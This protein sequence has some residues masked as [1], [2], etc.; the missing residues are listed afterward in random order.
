VTKFKKELIKLTAQRKQ[1]LEE[2]QAAIEYAQQQKQENDNLNNKLTNLDKG[3][4]NEYG[5]RVDSQSEQ[6][7]RLFKEAYDAGDSEKWQKLKMLWLN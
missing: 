7:K 2:A 5:T 1:A 4:I 6:A 3:Y